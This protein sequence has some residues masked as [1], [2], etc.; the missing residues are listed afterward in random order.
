ML[1]IGINSRPTGAHLAGWRHPDSWKPVV[2]N[3]ANIVKVAEI[4][5]RGKCD[6]VFLADANG[7][8]HMSDPVL[9]EACG[10]SARPAAYEPL[11]VLSA[12]A[13]KTSH[14]GLVGTATT[15]YEEPYLLARKF[16]SLDHLSGGRAAWNLVTTSDPED[17]LNFNRD[18]HVGRTERY[19]RAGEFAQVVRG[20]WDSWAEDAFPEDRTTGQFLRSERVHVLNHQ[21]KHFS[22]RGPLNLARS[23]QGQPVLFSA[24][25]SEPGKELIASNAE[26]MFSVPGTKE[27]AQATYAD[28]KGRMA[29]YG[30]SPDSLKILPAFSAYVAET[31]EEAEA[32]YQELQSLIPEKLGVQ[33]L[34]K[35]LEMD[36]SGYPVDGPVPELTGEI[37]GGTSGRYLVANMIKREN[38]TI[39]EAY[40]RVL[41]APGG[42]VFKGGYL[43]VADMIE[44]W[45]RSKAC[46]GFIVGGSVMPIGIE[47]FVDMVIP[48]L[49]RRGIFRKEY[50]SNTLRGNLGLPIPRNAFFAA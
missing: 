5:E 41:G 6:F 49:Q 20:L 23:P 9:F 44:D 35:A 7:V 15:T 24:G 16:L 29:K 4:A 8:P 17:A 11:T 12:I 37:V 36:V 38:L 14:V 40:K 13:M 45:Y 30:R 33:F 1:V 47:R 31:D 46:D 43:R 19:E 3:L 21:G 34:S 28:I 25:Q 22:V 26:C 50:E 48:E 39:R 18:E 27:E 2:M 42:G 32:H 10:P